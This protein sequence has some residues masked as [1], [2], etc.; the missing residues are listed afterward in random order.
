VQRLGLENGLLSESFVF[1][2]RNRS[3]EVIAFMK[4]ITGARDP[5]NHLR[6]EAYGLAL[7]NKLGLQTGTAPHA[8]LCEDPP[9]L[10]IERA[11]GDT[12]GDLLINY[13]RGLISSLVVCDCLHAVGA[14]LKELHT[15]HGQPFDYK[16][17]ELLET[18]IAYCEDLLQ[19]AGPHLSRNHALQ[20][21]VSVFREEGAYLRKNGARCSLI[22]GDANTGNFLWD[23]STS[24]LSVIDLQRL[25]TQARKGAPA[26]AT[27]DYETFLYTL[28][29]FPNIG[30]KGLRGG[31]GEAILAFRSGYG[32]V[33]PHEE[34][35]FSTVRHI[36]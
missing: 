4:M 32:E 20:Q 28:G 36:R 16:G 22:H 7:F 3:R 1:E 13:E 23:T 10:W 2:V 27:H 9:S 25:G 8:H 11:P 12:P 15:R 21:V 18:Y 24:R 17:A 35:F 29:F 30:F 14:F 19:Q 31:L 26:F 5:L 34:R 33:N 6:D